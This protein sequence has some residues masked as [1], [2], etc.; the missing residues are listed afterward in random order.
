MIKGII[1]ILQSLILVTLVNAESYDPAVRT[2]IQPFVEKA[3]KETGY[4]QQQISNILKNVQK[5]DRVISKIKKPYEN[6]SWAK[7][8]TFFIKPK[9]ISAANQFKKSH[10]MELQQQTK[11]TSIPANTITAIIGVETFF[12]KTKFEFNA[13]ESLATLSFDYPP[14]SKFFSSELIALLKIAKRSN[15]PPHTFKSSYAGAIGI[16]QFMPSS[17][18]Q[19]AKSETHEHPN[20]IDSYQDS[21]SSIANYLAKKGKW[22]KDGKFVTY[23]PRETIGIKT[24]KDE[25]FSKFKSSTEIKYYSEISGQ[26]AKGIWCS[27]QKSCWILHNN[28]FSILSYNG[29]PK[30][31]MAI[32]KLSE[33]IT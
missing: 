26:T 21:I 30:Y 29:S 8:Q 11:L 27:D 17:Y 15:Q 19:Y 1:L 9:M 4:T 13:L 28:F 16:P 2:D 32:V 14:R 20:I 23:V 33:K 24:D 22:Q 12:G 5:N 10:Q 6:F 3:A 31:A 7:Y 25:Y 18:L